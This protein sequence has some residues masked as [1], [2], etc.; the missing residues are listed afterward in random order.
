MRYR[1]IGDRPANEDGSV[2]ALGYT[3]VDLSASYRTGPYQLS[4]TVENLF[5]SEWSEAQFDTESRLQDEIDPV[6]EI[7]FTPGNPL[8]ARIGLSYFF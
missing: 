4:A 2:T 3:V 8:N 6:T 7:H 5:D 1:H